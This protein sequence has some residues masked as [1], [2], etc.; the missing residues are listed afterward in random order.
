[1]PAFAAGDLVDLIEK[2][3]ARVFHTVDGGARDLLH[4]DQA[5]LFFLN[6]VL[7]GLINLHLPLLGALAEDIGQHVLDVHV[8]F[9]DALVGDDF[10]GREIAL[11]SFDFDGA[12]VQLAFAQLLP[13]FLAG[14][15]GGF[16]QAGAGVD[17]Y[18]TRAGI[19]RTWRA[20]RQKNIK[21]P[22]FGVELGFIRHIFQLFFANHFDGDLHQI[23]NHGLNIPSDVADFRE[24]GSFNLE[25]GRVGQFGEAAGDFG[26]AHAGGPDHDDVLRDDFFGHFGRELLPPHAVAQCD[27]DGALRI[28]LPDN[29]LVEF[30]D[31]FARRQFVER[32]LFFF[33]GSG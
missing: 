16:A 21:Q 23:A 1:M 15:V 12:V 10:K 7:E 19:A 17:H 9:L 26:L 24:L 33:S 2:D 13:Q 28:F 18:A 4:V 11:A 32:D 31:D 8:H 14:A 3:D 20:R 30:S 25:E 5:L 22:L 6:Q 29:V 27:G